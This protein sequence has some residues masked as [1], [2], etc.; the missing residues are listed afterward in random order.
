LFEIRALRRMNQREKKGQEVG[1][2]ANEELH[3]L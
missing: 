2:A 3:N 1:R